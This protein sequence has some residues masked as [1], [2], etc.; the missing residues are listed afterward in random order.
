M[1]SAVRSYRLLLQLD[2]VSNSIPF[3]SEEDGLYDEIDIDAAEADV[4]DV[5]EDIQ[6]AIAL[7]LKCHRTR[8]RSPGG[9]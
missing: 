1:V 3:G 7:V 8:A 2:L 4:D 9:L 6:H 5:F